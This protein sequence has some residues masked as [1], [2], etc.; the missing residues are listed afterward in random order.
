MTSLIFLPTITCCSTLHYIIAAI[1]Y[2][3]VLWLHSYTS[4]LHSTATVGHLLLWNSI[5]LSWV[6]HPLNIK[7]WAHTQPLSMQVALIAQLVEHCTFNA[8]VV[9]LNPIQSLKF[10]QVFF[11][12]SVM[13]AFMYIILITLYFAVRPVLQDASKYYNWALIKCSLPSEH[14]TYFNL[15]RT[16]N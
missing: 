10:F 1:D 5:Y 6:S 4:L 12:S 16:H 11:S 7:G 14:I 2:I 8:T 3:V 13:T 9:G 15:P